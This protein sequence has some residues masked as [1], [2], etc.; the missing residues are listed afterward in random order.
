MRSDLASSGIVDCTLVAVMGVR[1]SSQN[2]GLGPVVLSPGDSDVD[3]V[4]EIGYGYL[5]TCL[6]ERS[7]RHQRHLWSE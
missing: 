1:L 3:L 4:D 7:G 6:P 2:C 5:L